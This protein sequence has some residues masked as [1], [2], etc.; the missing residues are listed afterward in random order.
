[1]NL[2]LRP[3]MVCM[4]VAVM[5]TAWAQE[6]ANALTGFQQNT[7]K[8]SIEWRTLATNLELRLARFLPCDPRIRSAIEETGRASDAR[9][10][11]LT[12]Y[13][14]AVSGK[15]KS[16]LDAIRKLMDQEEARKGDWSL[17][18]TEAEQERA[19][20]TE[21]NGFLAIGVNHVPAFAGAQKALSATTQTMLQMEAEARDRQTTGTQLAADLNALLTAGQTRQSAIEAELKSIAAE[22][23]RWAGYYAA[24]SSRAQTECEITNQDAG[25]PAARRPATKKG[26][27]K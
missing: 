2:M 14:M 18:N 17:E 1:M 23:T 16:Q 21:Q 7:A 9:I 25:A 6:P 22:G 24:R 27:G 8:R 13:W 5:G 15:S 26:S 12:T 11:A 20:V 4:W 10:A 3:L 19:M